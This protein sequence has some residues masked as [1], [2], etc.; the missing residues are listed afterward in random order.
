MNYRL[1][2]PKQVT[3][4]II[5]LAAVFIVIAAWPKKTKTTGDQADKATKVKAEA[6]TT[7]QLAE[8]IPV[9]GSFQA[10]TSVEIVPEITGQLQRLRLADNTLV[11][12][13]VAV[14]AGEVIAVIDHDIYLAQLAESQA[15]LE[16]GK[17]ALADA[18]REKKRII[19]LFEGGSATE[20]NKDK[21]VTAAQLAAASVKQAE[22]ALAR[23]KVTLDKATIESPITAVVSKKYVDE[24]NLVGPSTPLIK[25][26]QVDTLKVIGSVS[27]RHLPK[28]QSGKTEVKIKTDAYPED[29]FQGLVHRVGVA[30]DP[31]TRT[32]E[33][34]IRLPNPAGKLKPGMYARMTIF[35]SQKDN[36]LIL[37]ESALIRE[38]GEVFV[39]VVNGN[40][41]NLR[42]IE[43]GLPQGQ[44][45]ELIQ[46][47]SAGDVVV[48]HGKMQLK[49]GQDVEVVQEKQQ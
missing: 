18:E 22:A 4:I 46:G 40:K 33:V 37:P 36:A 21:A 45:W 25:I 49:D 20:Q 11:D 2:P 19:R 17:V 47:L 14:K 1:K 26:V 24:G 16:A 42:N 12:V 9:T 15:A 23:I 3:T 41:V 43:L 29:T 28:L 48:T 10:L 27:E 38:L 34:E 7:A 31:L 39:F 35:A 32:A 5:I 6:V 13:G 44:Y 8:T 30:V